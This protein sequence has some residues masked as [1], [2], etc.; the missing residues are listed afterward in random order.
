MPNRFFRQEGTAQR[1]A[2]LFP[3][4][5]YTCDMPLLYYPLKLLLDRGVEVL[6]VR[7][8]Y[9]LPAYQSLPQA[10]R[11]T[12]LAEDAKAVEK[13]ARLQGKYE[14]LVL[15]GKSIGTIALASLVPHEPEAV[16]IWLTPL[17]RN[18]LVVTAA[19]QNRGAALFV[20]G[21]ADDLYD[22]AALDKIRTAT[23]AEAQLIEG[24]NHSLEIAGDFFASLHALEQVMQAIVRFLDRQGI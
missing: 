12:W 1:L 18:P 19:K 2:V 24:G 14:R 8:D 11:A 4:V 13:A 10:E 17:L 15:V 5:Q 23:Q 6:Q 22:P 7:A 21:T 9:T 16:T 20:A 3:G